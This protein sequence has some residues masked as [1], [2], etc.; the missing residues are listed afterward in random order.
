MK[1]QRKR[2]IITRNNDT[3]IFCGLARHYEFKKIDEIGNTSI[4]TYAS[5]EKA[6]A[7]FE[8]S[9]SYIDF[10]YNILEVVETIEC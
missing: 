1:I 7:S 8:L 6:R 9:W 4:K 3:E 2:Y 10:K 5:R